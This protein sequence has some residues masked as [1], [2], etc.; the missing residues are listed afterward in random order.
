MEITGITADSRKVKPGDLFVCLPGFTVD[1]H[2][3]AAKAIELGAAAILAEKEIDVTGTVVMVPD[4]R[5]AQA[6]LADRFYQSPTQ[7]LRLIGVTGTNGK[8]TTTHLID[9]ILQDRG[10]RNGLIG[11]IH[12]RIGDVVEESKNTTPDILELQH[13]FRRMRDLDTDYAIMEISSHALDMGRVRGV[14]VHTAV[15][16]NL[17]QDH[18]DYHGSMENYKHAK[19]LLFAQLGNQ[20]STDTDRIKTAVLNADDEASEFFARVAPVRIVT[21]GIDQ[22]ADVRATNIRVTAHGTSCTIETFAG[23]LDFHLQLMGKFNVYNSLAAIATALAEGVTLAECKESLEQIKGVNGRFEPVAAGQ[24]FTVIVDY[25]HTP[26]SLENA[27]LTVKEFA[28]GRVT[29]VVGCG[30]DRDRTKRPIMAQIA[31]KYADTSVFTSDNP[32]SE[33]PDAILADMIAGLG[34]VSEERYTTI[35]DRREAIT[36]AIND[37][38]AG[39]V[40]L[41]AGKGHETYQIVKGQVHSF[42]D[43]EVA[44]EAILKRQS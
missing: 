20:Y 1:G 12:M 19:S 28:Q 2:D 25:S 32:R 21:Y 17:T 23:T 29:C 27:L 37:A 10:K 34:A 41:I 39:D 35:T 13:A 14:N 5:R 4:T 6:L 43:R 26:D 36:H 9:K 42:D 33:E 11:T 7:E 8:T 38:S 16:T 24:D 22:P 30:G 44:R 18:L 31:T 3:Y 40:I 15:F